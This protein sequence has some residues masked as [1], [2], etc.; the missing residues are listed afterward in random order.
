MLSHGTTYTKK[1]KRTLPNY[2]Y[3]NGMPQIGHSQFVK[4]SIAKSDFAS[5]EIGKRWR[6]IK[7][8][9][10]KRLSENAFNG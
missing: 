8:K 5:K 7:H 2:F 6:E 10:G 4:C 1:K 3:F 9:F